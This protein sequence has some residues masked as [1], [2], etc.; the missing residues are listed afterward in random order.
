MLGIH[1][2]NPPF[3][4]CP[5]LGST[6]VYP[7]HANPV[8]QWKT[9]TECLTSQYP[10]SLEPLNLLHLNHR[11]QVST[12]AIAT[13]NHK[14]KLNSKPRKCWLLVWN[15]EWYHIYHSILL[16]PLPPSLSTPF[17]A[18]W[19]TPLTNKP[20]VHS[21]LPRLQSNQTDGTL[22]LVIHSYAAVYI[23]IRIY[24]TAR[25]LKQGKH[26]PRAL[27]VQ[28]VQNCSILAKGWYSFNLRILTDFLQNIFQRL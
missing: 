21:A 20:Y 2:S 15:C 14:Q 8:W 27:R 16:F 23:L 5:S 13:C 4:A 25:D 6:L 19:A 1:T 17:P 26:P 11:N 9:H 28:M 7:F 12:M 22:S 10:G 18:W 24:D 3:S